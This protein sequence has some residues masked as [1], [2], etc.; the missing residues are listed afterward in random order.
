MQRSF[1][2]IYFLWTWTADSYEWDSEKAHKAALKERNRQAKQAR[3]EG[4]KVKN[5]TLKN[6]IVSKGGP[7]TKNAHIQL[8]VNIY[9]FDAE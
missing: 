1:N 8:Y 3:L 9:G 5:W 6:Q 2:P 4:K 7:G